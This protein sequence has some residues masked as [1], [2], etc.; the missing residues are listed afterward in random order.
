MLSLPRAHVQ[1][2]IGEL[3]SNKP[4]DGAKKKKMGVGSPNY[5]TAREVLVTTVL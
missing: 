5:W 3:G 4:E 1:P 2:L